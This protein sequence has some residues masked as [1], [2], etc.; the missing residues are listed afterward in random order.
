MLKAKAQ[1]LSTTTKI[2]KRNRIGRELRVANCDKCGLPIDICVCDEI[3]K[4]VTHKSLEKQIIDLWASKGYNVLEQQ[5]Q[6]L[7]K[8]GKIKWTI[9]AERK[10]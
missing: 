9:K 1:R 6:T 3:K 10:K 5:V 8:T 2:K 4:N 7:K